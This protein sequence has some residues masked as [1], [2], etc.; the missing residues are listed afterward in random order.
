MA[1]GFPGLVKNPGANLRL[2]N[3]VV[4]DVLFG[5]CFSDPGY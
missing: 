2:G 4:L 5:P 1:R 3:L